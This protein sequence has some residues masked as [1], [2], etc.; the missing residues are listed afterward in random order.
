MTPG[1]EE[2]RPAAL[3]VASNAVASDSSLIGLAYPDRETAEAAAAELEALGDE[4]KAKVRDSAIVVKVA[5]DRVELHQTRELSV[6]E[7][8]IAG[9]TV[10]FLLGLA[11]GGPIGAAVAGMVAGGGFGVFD[12]GIQNKQ[13][14]KLGQELEPGHAA[15][16]LL[17]EKA[18]WTELRDRLA[19]HH[20]E[21]LLAELSEEALAALA[22]E[23]TES[24]SGGA[25]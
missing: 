21:V 2:T 11:V 10:G 24:D 8:L 6:G 25:P 20:G 4:H 3:L 19:L 9:G 12:T 22:P 1:H 13:L 16:V 14:R 15:L 23:R 7:G 17:V 5:G 18:H